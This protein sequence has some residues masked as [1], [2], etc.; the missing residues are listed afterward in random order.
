M[1]Y[2]RFHSTETSILKLACDAL[3]AADLGIVTLLGLLDLSAA[4]DTVD[5][6]I[7]INRLQSTFGIHGTVLKW[8]TSFITN[9]MQTVNFAGQQSTIVT[10]MCG[11]PQG[12]ALGPVLFLLYTANVTVIAQRHGFLAYSYADDTQ[13]Y[14]LSSEAAP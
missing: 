7:L 9:R 12:S 6:H 5:H 4:F 2:R 3:L 1:A 10:V 8:V 11:V 14:F 13:I